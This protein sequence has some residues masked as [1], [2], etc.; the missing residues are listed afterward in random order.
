MKKFLSMTLLLTAMFLTFSA[1]SKD[2][3]DVVTTYTLVFDAYSGISTTVRLFEC[4]DNGEK[5]GNKSIKCK[6]GDSHT[7]TADPGVSKVKVYVSM[8]SISGN[9]SKWVQQVFILKKGGDT[10]IT[11]DD[12]TVVGPNE[13]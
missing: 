7:F 11:M 4:N 5:I 8:E 1:C 3:D 2:D 6:T 12:K 13:P 9:I 10:K